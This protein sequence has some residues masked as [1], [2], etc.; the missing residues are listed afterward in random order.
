MVDAGTE[1]VEQHVNTL[2]VGDGNL[3]FAL[4]LHRR[5]GL[6]ARLTASVL[7]PRCVVDDATTQNALSL[8]Q[9][10]VRVEFGID[11]TRPSSMHKLHP[12][13]FDRIIFNFPLR[14]TVSGSIQ[15]AVRG[16]TS[17]QLVSDFL[18]GLRDSPIL[19]AGVWRTNSGLLPNIL[20]ISVC[21]ANARL[22]CCRRGNISCTSTIFAEKHRSTC[23]R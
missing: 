2:L 8:R 9:V 23:R 15:S 10:G 3:S 5:E 19:Q 1:R 11:V 12:R 16:G 21:Q 20:H 14:D 22:K 13:V 17:G 6:G 4:A 18:T 7:Q